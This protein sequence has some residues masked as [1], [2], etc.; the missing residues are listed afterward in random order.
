[1]TTSFPHTDELLSS[2]PFDFGERGDA[3]FLASFKEMVAHHCA[4]NPLIARLWAD[5]GLGPEMLTRPDDLARAPFVMVN[6]FK[7][8]DLRTARPDE[9]ALTLTSSGTSGQ[10]SK[11]VLDARSLAAVKALVR[12]VFTA[13]GM[14]S[15]TATS[16][17]C[18]TYDPAKAKDLG[19]AFSDELLTSLTPVASTYYAIRW[20]DAASD[21]V[22]DDVDVVEHLRQ[23]ERQPNPVR[24]LGFPAFLEQ[25]LD[26]RE[27]SFRFAA[28]SWVITG[29]G[30][31]GKAALEIPKPA[32]KERVAAATGIPLSHIRDSY[33]FVEHGIPYVDCELGRLH[34]PSYAR[35]LVRDPVDLKVLPPGE[36]GL[37]Q[38]LCSYNSSYPCFNVLSTDYGMLERCACGKAG[39]TLTLTGRAGLSRHRGC[40]LAAAEL[41]RS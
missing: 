19:T 14:A 35:V 3:R 12:R 41:L 17:L 6:L 2:D 25:V 30:W 7:E 18:F 22:F 28:D 33:G 29:G 40:A 37:L 1:M 4:H 36:S 23:L 21:F 11:Q 15:S 8:R 10:K 27:L 24:I 13:L 9:V 31:K 34:V 16:Y 5:A 32:F 26:G 20:Q 39:M 38:F